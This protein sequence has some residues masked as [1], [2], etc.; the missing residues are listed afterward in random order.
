MLTG[1]A[2]VDEPKNLITATQTFEVF[3]P[4]ARPRAKS[5]PLGNIFRDRAL[6]VDIPSSSGTRNCS[7]RN[8]DFRVVK[9]FP[10][11]QRYFFRMQLMQA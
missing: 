2:W 9:K 1:L 7:L 11:G 4:T 5:P 3:T 10:Q 6:P 8:E